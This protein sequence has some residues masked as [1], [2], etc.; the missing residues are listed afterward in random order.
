MNNNNSENDLN[1]FLSQMS[2]FL[3]DNNFVAAMLDENS[4]FNNPNFQVSQRQ[5]EITENCPSINY[6]EWQILEEIKEDDI[7]APEFPNY[8]ETN[9]MEIE[10]D[11]DKNESNKITKDPINFGAMPNENDFFNQPNFQESQNQE[12][13][14]A[15]LP[16]FPNFNETHQMEIED[17]N[18][19]NES[20]KITKELREKMKLRFN[21]EAQGILVFRPNSDPEGKDMN[22]PNSDP[23]GKDMNKDKVISN[24]C[25][26]VFW[27]EKNIENC[28][29]DLM[30]I[31]S[32]K[33]Y[34]AYRDKN[35]LTEQNK[36]HVLSVLG[37]ALKK[38]KEK[39]EIDCQNNFKSI[40][41]L[42]KTKIFLGT[43]AFIARFMDDQN[44]KNIQNIYIAL[45]KDEYFRKFFS[46]IKAKNPSA[47]KN[48]ILRLIFENSDLK[49]TVDEDLQ[50]N[51]K[52]Q[53]LEKC[54]TTTT[55][56]FK[57]GEW[58]GESGHRSGE[59]GTKKDHRRVYVCRACY[60]KGKKP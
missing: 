31:F 45:S 58:M 26:Y 44:Q 51:S 36:K 9:Q 16:K 54:N 21:N 38:K 39:F 27:V 56:F 11:N 18:N 32:Y 34:L 19:K 4:F 15:N 23:K 37:R 57:D 47:E 24:L 40:E 49:K 41:E 43:E 2:E 42:T 59:C 28:P 25:Q 53:V 3:S 10:D 13:I 7:N 48:P 35:K 29:Q 52:E 33:Y 60:N 22:K 20:N 55:C 30:N 17:N 14:K 12:G 6:G 46:Q 5:E 50:R 8:N 1:L